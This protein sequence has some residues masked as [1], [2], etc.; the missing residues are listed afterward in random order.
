MFQKGIKNVINRLKHKN[1]GMELEIR[2]SLIFWRYED[3]WSLNGSVLHHINVILRLLFLWFYV[4]ITCILFV[5]LYVIFYVFYL[6][7]LNNSES[8]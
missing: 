7:S 5:T 6:L 2:K 4:D 1:I 8:E 3:Y